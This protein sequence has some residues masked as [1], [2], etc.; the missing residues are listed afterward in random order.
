MSEALRAALRL[1]EL[2]GF[3]SRRLRQF[4]DRFGSPEAFLDGAGA[5]DDRWA[6]VARALARPLPD[7]DRRLADWQAH[8]TLQGVFDPGFPEALRQLADPPFVIGWQ[9]MSPTEWPQPRIVIVGTRRPSGY[10]RQVAR[11]FAGE[12][13]AA[14]AIVGSGLA[15][16]VDA[17]A[18]EGALE[19]GLGFAVLPTGLDEV[20]PRQHAR[21][22]AAVGK[23]GTLLSE[24][25]PRTA[26]QSWSFVAR[27][28]LLAALADVVVVVEGESRSG[29]LITAD[30]AL[31][32]GREVMAVPGRVGDALAEGPLALLRR[33]AAPAIS[34]DD[35]LTAAGYVSTARVNIPEQAAVPD[36]LRGLLELI[37]PAG[38]IHVDDLAGRARRAVPELLA[39]LLELE[40]SGYVQTLPGK[41]FERSLPRGRI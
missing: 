32:L 34:V 13:A 20:A 17:A 37:P 14:G 15:L 7:E 2:P 25:P 29:S 40:L 12:L 39:D 23:R 28:R 21:L 8:G 16:G 22:A 36:E 18:H 6:P 5:R 1:R 30:L 9:G 38:S 3:G 24:F 4:L 33:G 31:E 27:N 26:A 10:G 35:I 41:H 11:R 19:T